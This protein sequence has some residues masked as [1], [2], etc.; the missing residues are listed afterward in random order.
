MAKRMLMKKM[1]STKKMSP[2]LA[3]A[4]AMY[5]KGGMVKPKGKGAC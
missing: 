3:T 4:S 2:K 1:G 5:S